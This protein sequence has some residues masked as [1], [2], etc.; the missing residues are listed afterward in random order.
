VA[1]TQVGSWRLTA[2]SWHTAGVKRGTFLS[3][4]TLVIGASGCGDAEGDGDSTSG[5]T[6]PIEPHVTLQVSGVDVAALCAQA[7]VVQVRLRASV[8]GCVSPPP[9]P[10]T[11]P[12]PKPVIL[13]DVVAC[14]GSDSETVSVD[15]ELR[16][17]YYADVVSVDGDGSESGT[18]TSHDGGVEIVVD[19]DD[20]DSGATFELTQIAGACPDP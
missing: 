17:R 2:D 11:Q 9:A 15:V 14:P 6:G 20:L 12:N 19:T 3:I 4:L 10:C 13:G 5:T 7:D 8:M 1:G 18:C 16:A